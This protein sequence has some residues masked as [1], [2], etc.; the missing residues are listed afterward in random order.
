MYE[1]TNNWSRDGNLSSLAKSQ[2]IIHNQ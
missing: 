2:L 1:F